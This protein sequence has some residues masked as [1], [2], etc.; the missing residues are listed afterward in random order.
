MHRITR[1]IGDACARRPWAT[2]GMWAVAAAV[3][4][5]LAGTAGGS[6]ADD[7]VAPGSQ[8][9]EAMVL[10]EERFP[11]AA[12]GSA[13]AVFAAPEGERL[14]RH[15]PTVEAA[16]A[17][18]AG[19][20]H[21]T[22]VA[23]PFTAGTV[24]PDGRIGFAEI[25][26]DRP[27]TELGPSPVTAVADAIAPA[28]E[29]GVAAELGGDA[30]FVNAET[31]TSGA[32]AAGLL[33]A[34]VVLVVAFGTIVAAL[35][36][37]A[38]TLVAVAVGVGGITLLANAMEVSSAAPTIGA[39]IG[40][41]VGIDY[42]LFVMAR[43]REHRAAGEDNRTALSDA[44]GSAGSAVLLA[45]GTVV[46]AMAA[47]VL[48]GLGF[49]A[50][51]GLSTSL[52]VL[53]AVATALTLLP[54]LLS[55]LGDR[56]DAGRLIGRRRLTPRTQETA[57]WRFAHRVS[58][59][60]WPY[61][62]AAAAVLLALAAP[63]LRMETG[64]PD[65]GDDS[66]GTTHRRAYDLLADGFGPGFNA[67]LLLVAD[68][69]RPGVDAAAVPALAERVAADPGIVMV[70]EPRTSPAGDTVVLPMV[71][72]TAPADPG[73]AQTLER[74]RGLVPGNVAVSGLTAMTVDLTGQLAD[75]LPIFVGAILAASFLLLM[76]VF[77]S[78]VVPLKAVVMNLLSIGGAYGVVVA[79]F[80]WGW[81]AD[82]FGLE[83]TY[84]IASPLPTIFFA[85]LFGLS[86]DYEVFLLSRIREAYDATGDNT[87]SVARGTAATGRVITSA[88]LIMT[89]VFASFVA[90]PSPLVK[91]L[92][93]GLATAIVLDATIVRMVLVPASMAL[94]GRANWWLPGWLD[95]RLP[96]VRVEEA[97]VPG[98]AERVL[99]SR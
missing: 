10:L 32:E 95:R 80:Q 93:L 71:P 42:A 70:G 88:A 97:E 43:Y 33:A 54:A 85:V 4:L 99:A 5:G 51:I 48:T 36:P 91:M 44:M 47:L 38:L 6:F 77:R 76:L 9:E 15:R 3:V 53:V 92:G 59:R 52:V 67:P 83:E 29:A 8:S 1:R 23:D 49:L 90:D 86:M 25:T 35:L 68:L 12:G 55:L 22:G 34:L 65:A 57:W 21:V 26:F 31:E 98:Q 13:L 64:F 28:R 2:I 40:L 16:V 73:T 81:L 37:I 87:E 66:A 62:I 41:G 75:T 14:E 69:R 18:I 89:V 58:G 46:V 74:V 79:V 82:L 39:M 20:E 7:L 60:P 72:T 84:L 96:H 61:L 78:V 24:S 30:A 27:S 11:E 94:M 19:V 63:A 17:R 50:S 45:G 56:V